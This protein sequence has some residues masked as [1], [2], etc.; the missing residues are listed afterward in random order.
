LHEHEYGSLDGKNPA[1]QPLRCHVEH[2]AVQAETVDKA[3]TARD[4]QPKG[5]R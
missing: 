1:A 5:K 3:K 4:Q 2:Q